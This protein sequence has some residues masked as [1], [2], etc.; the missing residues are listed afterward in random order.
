MEEDNFGRGIAFGA[1][2]S[3]AVWVVVIVVVFAIL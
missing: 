3:G 2:V 1:V